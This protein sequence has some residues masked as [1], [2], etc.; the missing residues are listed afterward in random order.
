M[1]TEFFFLQTEKNRSPETPT[2]PAPLWKGH[3]FIGL[4]PGNYVTVPEWLTELQ[5]ECTRDN[6]EQDEQHQNRA[7]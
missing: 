5:N 7:C 4:C 6:N 1:E 2:V 3:F